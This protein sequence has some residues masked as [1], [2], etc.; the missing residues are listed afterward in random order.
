[1]KKKEFKNLVSDMLDNLGNTPEDIAEYLHSTGIKGVG[2]TATG[3]VTTRYLNAV[4]AADPAIES[5]KVQ[6]TYVQIHRKGWFLPIR[7]QLPKSLQEF[8]QL[9]DAYHYPRLI[10]EHSTTQRAVEELKQNYE[11]ALN[12]SI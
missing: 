8:I 4:M 3:C 11:K 12:G 5:I 9:Y 1:M 10:E 2:T 7:I 6:F